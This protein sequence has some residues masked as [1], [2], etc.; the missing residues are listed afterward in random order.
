MTRGVSNLRGAPLFLRPS[1]V[2]ALIGD[3]E[4]IARHVVAVPLLPVALVDQAAPSVLAAPE[5]NGEI[6]RFDTAHGA[7]A[8]D[9][10]TEWEPADWPDAPLPDAPLP[11]VA[12]PD[13]DRPEAPA[14]DSH[15]FDCSRPPV[16]ESGLAGM[17]AGENARQCQL[18][19]AEASAPKRS[20]QP[21]PEVVRH[22]VPRLTDGLY[23]S[24]RRA[25]ERALEAPVDRAALP[26][27]AAQL[28]REASQGEALCLEKPK[29]ID[30]ARVAAAH[31]NHA[32]RP[33]AARKP[34]GPA[35]SREE[36]P[37]CGIPGWKGCDHFLPCEDSVR[38]LSDEHIS[39]ARP[40][41]RS[42]V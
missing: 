38:D 6:T 20:P 8:N 22:R 17:A 3:V 21:A 23:R 37:R 24:A 33:A 31:R 25:D 18:A 14:P 26:S 28:I 30:W 11:D 13:L 7:P 36:C 16:E 41:R 27:R 32:P 34:I 39:S 19:K 4:T 1:V 9:M 5:P 15:E 2:R 29:P 10:R 12:D 35:P 42:P 40:G